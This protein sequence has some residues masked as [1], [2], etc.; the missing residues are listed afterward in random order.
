MVYVCLLLKICAKLKTKK[1]VWQNVSFLIGYSSRHF[2]FPKLHQ[3]FQNLVYI[4]FPHL[5][6]L[7]G[8]MSPIDCFSLNIPCRRLI[9]ASIFAVHNLSS[10]NLLMALAILLHSYSLTVHLSI[11]ITNLTFWVKSY[12]QPI[13]IFRSVYLPFVRY[14]ILNRNKESK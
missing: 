4:L 13:D 6:L 5:S 3:Y 12:S 2:S 11:T 7:S 1:K 14:S 8:E 10:R 9:W